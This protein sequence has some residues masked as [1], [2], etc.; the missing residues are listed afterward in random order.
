MAVVIIT[1]HADG[2]NEYIKNASNYPTNEDSVLAIGYGVTTEDS[3]TAQMQFTNTAKFWNN[4]EKNQFIHFTCAFTPNEASNAKTAMKITDKALDPFKN[5]HL[6]LSGIHQK[7]MDNSDF[8]SH[9]FV[10][11]TNYNNGSMIYADNKTTFPVAQ[12]IADMTGEVCTLIKKQEGNMKKDF[13][14]KFYPRNSSEY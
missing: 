1:T 6:I 8:H 2:G 5:N 10:H 4:Q 7:N 3:N 13:R 11:T 9:S 14:Q 12:R